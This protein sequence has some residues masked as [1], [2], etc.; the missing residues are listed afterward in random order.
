MPAAQFVIA[1]DTKDDLDVIEYL[2]SFSD[3]ERSVIVLS[4]IRDQMQGSN[5]ES[6]ILDNI[7]DVQTKLDDLQ[8]G[9]AQLKLGAIVGLTG[10]P[11]EFH[12]AESNID[13]LT[14]F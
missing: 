4:A 6:Q 12:E 14:K 9:L 3:S 7:R 11:G 2:Q 5:F 10:R 8:R 13:Q 1:V